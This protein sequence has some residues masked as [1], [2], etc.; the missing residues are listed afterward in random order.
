[1][2]VTLSLNVHE[3]YIILQFSKFS[4]SYVMV[5]IEL[6]FFSSSKK[7]RNPFYPPIINP[8]LVC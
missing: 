5:G 2:V 6:R 8:F 7:D 1:M 3:I 4:I